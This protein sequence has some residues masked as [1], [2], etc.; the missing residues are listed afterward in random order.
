MSIC[1]IGSEY[2]YI[3]INNKTNEK[4]SM[5]NVIDEAYTFS[6][7]TAIEVVLQNLTGIKKALIPSYCCDSMIV[8]FREA[9]IEVE[10]YDVFWDNGL[11]EKI[12][13][14]NDVDLVLWCNYF[15]FK[16]PMPDFSRFIARGGIVLED[17]THS[18]LSDSPF[19]SQSQYIIASIRKWFPLICGGYCA[20]LV[21]KLQNKPMLEVP[22]EYIDTK[23]LA[24]KQKAMYLINEDSIIKDEYMNNFSWSNHWLAN[25]YSGL[26]IDQESKD[27]I[28]AID[29]SEIKSIRKRN[30]LVVYEYLNKNEEVFPIFEELDVDC[31]LFVPIV[32]TSKM[33]RDELRQEL[34]SQKVYCPIHWPTPKYNCNSNLYD[35]ELS[36]ICDQRYNEEDMKRMMQIFCK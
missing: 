4:I 33:K 17:I 36:L 14:K 28:D 29:I 12:D 21:G 13:I 15:G 23:K 25:N 2:H 18:Y 11:K 35:L 7:R 9:N 6:G 16:R 8:P 22:N 5:F 19:H 30:A 24:M 31:P 10:F 3:P 1:E 20:S 26:R 27:Y 32:C 34:I